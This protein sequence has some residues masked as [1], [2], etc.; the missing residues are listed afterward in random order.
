M[1]DT[2]LEIA[3]KLATKFE[4]EG[5]KLT[6]EKDA[7]NATLPETITAEQAASVH[8]HDKNFYAGFTKAAGE[9]G[10]EVL[11]D[12]AQYANV[13]A[14]THVGNSTM[15]VLIE[16]SAEVSA[17]PAKKG[18]QPQTRTVQGYTTAR[19]NTKLGT[20]VKAVRDHIH[21]T[22]NDILG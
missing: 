10:L 18:E 1:K 19:L 16:R 5:N 4:V 11:K 13:E 14:T 20:E 7:Y 2:T 15:T 22:A 3:R 9:R 21:N 17:G 12:N 8:T 6:L